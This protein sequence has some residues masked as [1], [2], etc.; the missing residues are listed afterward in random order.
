MNATRE[1]TATTRPGGGA[2]L[3]PSNPRPRRGNFLLVV[4]VLPLAVGGGA[5]VFLSL[6]WKPAGAAGPA[7]HT[8][9]FEKLQQTVVAR[10]DLEPAESSEVFCRA[11]SSLYGRIFATTIEWVVDNGAVVRKGDLL[12]QLDDDAYRDELVNRKILLAQ[13]Q[14]DC[15]VA[16][17]NCKIVESQNQNLISRAETAVALASLDLQKFVEGDAESTR[18]DLEARALEA[19]SMEE[20]WRQRSAWSRRMARK[21]FVSPAQLRADENGLQAAEVALKKIRDE[22]RVFTT[23]TRTQKK[24]QLESGQ[25]RQA[26]E[27]LERCRLQARARSAQAEM[28]RLTRKRIYQRRLDRLHEVE[29]QIA[30]CRIHSPRDGVVI[31]H[32]PEQGW[33]GAGSTQGIVAQGE[34]VREGQL[35]LRVADL[36][37]MQAKVWIQEALVPRVHG[38]IREDTA[39]NQLASLLDPLE[40]AERPRPEPRL[41]AA[42]QEAIIRVTALPGQSLRGHVKQVAAVP[43]NLYGRSDDIKLYQAVVCIDDSVHGLR[44]DETA[45]VRIQTEATTEPVLTVPVQ[46]I[47]GSA[48]MGKTRECLVATADGIEEREIVVGVQNGDRAEVRQGLRPGDEVVL[49]PETLLD[50]ANAEHFRS[51]AGSAPRAGVK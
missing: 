46:A 12:V 16:E 31:Y 15:V 21:G 38:E 29:E 18:Q 7:T 23:Y 28:E 11:K 3:R 44:P 35:L 37:R 22:Q 45:E 48:G 4:C 26:R 13:A 49:H 51:S 40:F 8:V 9:G 42:G 41:L 24:V 1:R 36:S 39:A 14:A 17:E 19:E 50:A 2:V 47:F 5:T 6:A 30:R 25:L 27:A 43:A 10:G 32:V 20:M 33:F 34:T